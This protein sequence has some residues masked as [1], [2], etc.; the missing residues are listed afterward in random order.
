MRL[1]VPGAISKDRLV[2][3][4]MADSPRDEIV[5][6]SLR[7]AVYELQTNALPDNFTLPSDL[8]SL[9]SRRVPVHKFEKESSVRQIL[10]SRGVVRYF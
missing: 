3:R 2:R 5:S 7:Y 6:G 9:L 4:A 8:D 10:V 1:R